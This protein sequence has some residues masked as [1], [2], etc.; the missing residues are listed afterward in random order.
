MLQAKLWVAAGIVAALSLASAG[1]R[2]ESDP[3]L[4]EAAKAEGTVTWA[5]GLIVNQAVRPVAA[6]FEKKYGIRVEIANADNLLLRMT[7]EASAGKPTID[8]FDNA[9]DT[10]TAMRAADLI[11]PYASPETARYR[12]EHKDAENYWAS[13]CVFFYTVAINTDIVKPEDEPKSYEDLLDPKWK[14]KMVWQ[15]NENFAGPPSFIGARLISMGEEAGT[16]YLEKLAKQNI[17]RVP[18]NARKALDQV[19][20]GQYPLAITALNHHVV[21]SADQG[22][23]IKWLKIGPVASTAETVGLVK[24]AAHPNAAKLLFDYLLSA[25]G[26]NVLRE[27]NYLPADPNVPAKVP[28]LKP[29]QGGFTAVPILPSMNQEQLPKWLEIYKRLFVAG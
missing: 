4:I 5:S 18:G 9:G 6:A 14:D 13:C 1:A 19:I 10:I 28:E 16:A 2:A 7:N 20:L 8:I 24:G 11:V 12:P 29:E 15:N 26:Q 22:A 3:A 25:E 27:A 21:I 23:P 17:T